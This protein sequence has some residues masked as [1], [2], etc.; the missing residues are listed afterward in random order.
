MLR[1]EDVCVKKMEEDEED[2]L[3]YMEKKE[4]IVQNS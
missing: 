3:V 1:K 4:K 2:S